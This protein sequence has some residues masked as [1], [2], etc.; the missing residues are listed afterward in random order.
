MFR[1]S[2]ISVNTAC[3]VRGSH[4]DP[5]RDPVYVNGRALAFCC[6][7]CP[8]VFIQDPERYLRPMKISLRCPVVPSRRAI[9][10]SSLRVRLNQDIYYFSSMAALKRF[11][12]DPLRY[13]GKL[14]DPVTRERFRPTKSSPHVAF[15]GRDYW[16]AADSTLARFQAQPERFYERL[17]GS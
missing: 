12:K 7:P 16:F 9:L 3:P 2:T 4:V 11:R 10:D 1:D 8:S 17:A 15:R 14:T 13:C 5:A 6:T